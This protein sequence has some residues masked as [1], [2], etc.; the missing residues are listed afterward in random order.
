MKNCIFL[1]LL[2]LLSLIHA[3]SFAQISEGGEPLPPTMLRSTTPA[4]FVDMEPF[5]AQ[6]MLK[7]DSADAVRFRSAR[8]AKKFTTDLSPQNSGIRFTTADGTRVW[9]CGI[10]S[11]G[12]FSINLLFTQYHLPK[13]AK[14]FIYNSDRTHKIGAF[15]EKNNS[16]YYKLPTA[17]VYGDEV[18]VE[19]QEPADAEFKGSLTIGEVNHDYR[20]LTLRARPGSLTSNETC[21]IDAV[22]FPLYEEISQAVTLIIVNGNEYCTGCMVNNTSGDGTPYLLSAAHCFYPKNGAT[23]E[24]RAQNTVIFFNYQNPTCETTVV[25]PEEMSLASGTLVANE[26]SVDIALMRLAQKPPVYYRAFYA[27]WNASTPADYP[28]IG[29]HHPISKTKKIATSEKKLTLA[30]FDNSNPEYPIQSNVHWEIDTWLNGTTEAGSS[31]SPLFDSNKRLIG[32]L[33]G[34]ASYCSSPYNDYYYALQKVWSYYPDSTRQLKHWL[35]PENSGETQI[36]GM[37][38]YGDNNCTRMS[39]VGTEEQVTTTQLTGSQSGPLFGQNSLKSIEFAEQFTT[40]KKTT[41]YGFNFVAPQWNSNWNGKVKFKIYRGDDSPKTAIDS[42]T[43]NLSYLSYSLGSFKNISLPSGAASDHFVKLA[44]PLQVDSC[45]YI[46]YQVDYQSTDT[47][48][49]YN[50]ANRQTSIGT[51]FVRSSKSTSFVKSPLNTSLWIDP[52]VHLG[53]IILTPADT[54]APARIIFDKLTN[55][56]TFKGLNSG[57]NYH[58]RMYDAAGRLFIDQSIRVNEVVPLQKWHNGVFIVHLYGED[59]VLYKKIVIH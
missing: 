13:G 6:L 38:P 50:V 19:Y 4:L 17:P 39:N 31:G 58:L 25:G 29:I 23:S 54:V 42:C 30:S 7:E 46:S 44:N 57:I 55:L 26:P 49:V 18:I 24:Q 3:N 8:F 35:D 53:G 51:T 15:T 16:Q 20:G 22:C 10:R 45:F 11:K 41:L 36:N 21:H 5:D 1:P 12:A 32:A 33:T 28:Y 40:K 37:N 2:I 43:L 59:R 9:Q 52:T 27:G 34:G 47:F 56:L 14:L 48:S